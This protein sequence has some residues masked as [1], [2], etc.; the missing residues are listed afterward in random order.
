VSRRL[1]SSA[2]LLG[3]GYAVAAG[4]TW[5]LL[6]VPESNVLALTAS[7]LCLVFIAV[8]TGLATGGAAALARD[9]SP[10]LVAR[11]ALSG[12]PGFLVGLGLF[13]A[14][15]WI[16]GHADA[17]WST[18]RGE[19]DAV[20]LRYLDMT[21]TGP[22][23]TVVG[24][25]TWL[26][27][28]V[29]GLSVIVGPT[30]VGTDRELRGLGSGL[31]LA[32]GLAP[33]AAAAAGVLLVSE[34][35]WR[36]VFWRPPGL[37]ATNAEVVFAAVKLV[38]LYVFSIGIAALVLRVFVHGVYAGGLPGCAGFQLARDAG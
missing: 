18:H 16:T 15:W 20:F 31:R 32:F 13:A 36:V 3:I 1:L 25:G 9:G 2:M 12:L 37:P 11:R 24:W 28:W 33:I 6:N 34:G 4:L 29:I 30:V 23:H 17:W 5:A 27:R 22:L 21:R 14:L 19:V 26:L 10:G 35:V 7:A 38:L 8:T